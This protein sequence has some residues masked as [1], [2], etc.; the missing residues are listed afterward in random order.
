M[1][2]EG[3][4]DPNNRASGPKYYNFHGIWDLKLYY[5]GPWTLMVLHMD[6]TP[7]FHTKHQSVNASKLH[8]KSE[9]RAL[10]TALR[11]ARH[12]LSKSPNPISLN[13]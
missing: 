8:A 11:V 10:L 9:D 6:Y 1:Y 13:P 7:L 12:V 3:S 2:P 5:L 4:K